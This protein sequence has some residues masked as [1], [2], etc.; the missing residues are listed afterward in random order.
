MLLIYLNLKLKYS[1]SIF[2]LFFLARIFTPNQKNVSLPAANIV[3]LIT[4]LHCLR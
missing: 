1:Y 4:N 2:M 3:S